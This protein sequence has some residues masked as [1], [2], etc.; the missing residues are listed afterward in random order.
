MI[1][2]AIDPAEKTGWAISKELYGMEDFKLK[3]DQSFGY[4]LVKFKQ[5]ITTLIQ[6]ENVEFVAYERPSG[7]NASGLISHSKFVAIIEEYCTLNNI[8]YKGY[9][10]NEIKSFATGNGNAGKLL[11]IQAAIRL[12]KKPIRD[13]NI[14]DALHLLHLAKK[15]LS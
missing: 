1:I 9:S 15:D 6:T 10:A 8:P 3:R 4:K 5:F 14:A 12:Y 2:L 7:R 13:D 11:M